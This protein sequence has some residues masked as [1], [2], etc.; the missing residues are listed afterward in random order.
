MKPHLS[1][2]EL[3]EAIG[4]SESSIKRWIDDLTIAASR[5]AGGHR[6]IGMAEAVR[7]IR[8]SGLPVVRPQVLALPDLAAARSQVSPNRELKE[9]FL[10]ALL[11]GN[12]PVVRGAL[13]SVFLEGR[14]LADLCDTVVAPAMH[15]IGE[16]WTHDTQGI[17][18]EH[19]A[20]DLCCQALQSI[21][22]LLPPPGPEAPGAVG[23]APPGDPYLLPTLMASAV[24]TAEGWNAVNLGPDLPFASLLQAAAACRAALVWLAVSAEGLSGKAVP[25][26]QE[27]AARLEESGASLVVGGRACPRDLRPGTSP[28]FFSVSSMAELA[29]FARGLRQGNGTDRSQEA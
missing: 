3:G 24:L 7:F 11:D 15:R 29:A 17:F 21:R 22:T 25:E 1:P 26:L 20:T 13:L 2:K 14:S 9:L 28:Q 5:T 27:M 16:L 6:R 8:A 12:G 10:E 19:R 23:A 18:L 4:V